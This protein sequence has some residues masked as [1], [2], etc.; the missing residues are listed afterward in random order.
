MDLM[1]TPG[2]ALS[3]RENICFERAV[4]ANSFKHG[5]KRVYGV[6]VAKQ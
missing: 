5:G 1:S 3:R 2:D 6:T 4:S